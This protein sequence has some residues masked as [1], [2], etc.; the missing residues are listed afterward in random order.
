MSPTAAYNVVL[1]QSQETLR[2]CHR[3]W[4]D[5]GFPQNVQCT[6]L[7]FRIL[8]N[9]K[10]KLETYFSDLVQI[11]KYYK[12][13]SPWDYSAGYYTLHVLEYTHKKEKKV[14]DSVFPILDNEEELFT[15]SS[16]GRCTLGNPPVWLRTL[17]QRT[18]PT[19]R[20]AGAG[21]PPTLAESLRVD[22]VGSCADLPDA[23]LVA[24]MS[25]PS[26]AATSL[27]ALMSSTCSGHGHSGLYYYRLN[28]SRSRSP[29]IPRLLWTTII[30]FYEEFQLTLWRRGIPFLVNCIF[31]FIWG[32]RRSFS[33]CIVFFVF[34]HFFGIFISMLMYLVHVHFKWKV[35]PVS[36]VF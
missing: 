8:N 30:L 36:H 31:L 12:L 21:R 26:A 28:S 25:S 32:G 1:S 6:A 9:T 13:V 34:K 35:W 10:R 7:N 20:P 27:T 5:R 18:T 16:R 29:G 11:L 14:K 2:N 3:K 19:P 17:G 24:E 4:S 22:M 33:F 23:F 15:F